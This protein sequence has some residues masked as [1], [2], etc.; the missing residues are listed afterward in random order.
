MNYRDLERFREKFHWILL[1][2][3]STGTGA[4]RRLPELKWK[5]SVE[6]LA[7]LRVV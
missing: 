4:L 6:R 1:D 7:E 2:V 3:P 5:F